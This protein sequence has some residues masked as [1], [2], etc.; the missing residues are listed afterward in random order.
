MTSPNQPDRRIPVGNTL[1]TRQEILDALEANIIF[2][3]D[4][5]ADLLH[6]LGRVPSS[7]E[8]AHVVHDV[9]RIQGYIGGLL[10]QLARALRDDNV[11]AQHRQP[12]V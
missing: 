4:G 9:Q 7:P 12:E 8:Q 2:A 6:Y 5:A 1:M 10:L 11:Q 3:K